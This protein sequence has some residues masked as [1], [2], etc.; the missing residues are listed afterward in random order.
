MAEI[1]SIVSQYFADNKEIPVD[2]IEIKPEVRKYC[3]MNQC[4]NYG[5]NWTCPPAVGPLEDAAAKFSRYLNFL[6]V[7]HVY[8]LKN[9]FDLTGMKKGAADFQDRL[10]TVRR[11]LKEADFDF[12]VLGAGGCHLCPK[13]SYT[14]GEPCRRPGE[15]II[16]C[17]AY[18]I[19]VMSLMKKHDLKYNNGPNT[20][21]YIGGILSNK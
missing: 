3:E 10:Q 11:M 12:M 2:T 16:S 5:K 15:A 7:Y 13:C 8:T 1:Q 9:S 6:L 4:G 21:T 19:D 18:G 20:V 17:E 14:E